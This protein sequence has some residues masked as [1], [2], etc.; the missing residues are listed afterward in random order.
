MAIAF[1]VTQSAWAFQLTG[2]ANYSHSTKEPLP[3]H[4]YG[5]NCHTAANGCVL[6]SPE[7][8]QIIACVGE[9][10][11]PRTSPAGHTL[12]CRNEPWGSVYEN[13]GQECSSDGPCSPHDPCVKMFCEQIGQ[14][15]DDGTLPIMLEPGELVEDPTPSYCAQNS[16]S[17]ESCDECCRFRGNYWDRLPMNDPLRPTDQDFINFMGQ[18]FTACSAQFPTIINRGYIPALG[19]FR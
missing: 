16:E 2:P 5:P 19:G 13:W 11:D 3:Y 7:N 15:P 10:F 9:R 8:T 18:C 1:F 12:A 4:L 6:E 17:R 14:L